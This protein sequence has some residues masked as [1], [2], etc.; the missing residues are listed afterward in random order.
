MSVVSGDGR[1]NDTDILGHS[2]LREIHYRVLTS[3]QGE[4]NRVVFRYCIGDIAVTAL[5]LA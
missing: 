4:A 5:K 3:N 1:H 2:I